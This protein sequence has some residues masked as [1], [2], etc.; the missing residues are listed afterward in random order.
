[1]LVVRWRPR[2]PAITPSAISV[3]IPIGHRDGPLFC[4]FFCFSAEDET[5]ILYVAF[6]SVSEQWIRLIF[7]GIW[8]QITF[9]EIMLDYC[10]FAERGKATRA[11][12]LR[13]D[14]ERTPRFHIWCTLLHKFAFSA[15]L[16]RFPLRHLDI[17]SARC[18]HL[19]LSV[20]TVGE[21]KG[22]RLRA[23]TAEWKTRYN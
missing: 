9:S 20:P 18:I 5:I 21:M 2:T 15:S 10:Y 22:D 7:S 1:M 19:D 6:N 3:L 23:P 16:S 4:F 13:S 17:R 8:L 11:N 14:S 12:P